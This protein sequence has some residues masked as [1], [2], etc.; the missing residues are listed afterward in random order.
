MSWHVFGPVLGWSAL[1][2]LAWA[3]FGLGVALFAGRWNVVDT[4][5]SLGFCAVAVTSCIATIG[6]TGPDT[7]RRWLLLIC[8]LVWGVRLVLQG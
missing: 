1:A 8:I 2:T 4:M 5:W 7:T 6:T 3:L